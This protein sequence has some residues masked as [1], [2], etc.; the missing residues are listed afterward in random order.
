MN[1]YRL[2]VRVAVIVALGG[3]AACGAKTSTGASAGSDGPE[4]VVGTDASYAPFEFVDDKQDV[5]GFDVD[6][7]TAIAKRAGF[8]VRFIN[9]PWEGIFATLGKGNRDILASAITIN[10]E[11][12]GAVDFSDPYFDARQLI[13]VQKGENEIGSFRDLRGET[14]AV[15][16]GTTADEDLQRLVGRDNP[17]IRRYQTM[18]EALAAL[19]SGQVKALVGDNGVVSS[20]VRAHPDSGLFT[21]EDTQSFAPEHYGFAVKKG[22]KDL[23]A[24][25]NAGLAA[26]RADGSYD[27]LYKKYFGENK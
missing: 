5:R 16:V 3:L 20:F 1:L 15:Q 17:N 10:V 7:L 13:A 22:R 27:L 26:V 8:R 2:L 9:T 12:Q 21:V 11:R 19:V 23:L 14:V 18:N 4:Y 25:L 6:L 24:K